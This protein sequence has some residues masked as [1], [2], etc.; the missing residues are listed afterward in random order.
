M[1][2]PLKDLAK[3]EHLSSR[4][5]NHHN[6]QTD[7]ALFATSHIVRRRSPLIER[8]GKLFELFT[9]SRIRVLI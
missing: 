1:N 9:L 8:D 5:K 2:P 7:R 3:G 6:Q 4:K